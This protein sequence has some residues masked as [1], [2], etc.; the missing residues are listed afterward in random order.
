MR[1][2]IRDISIADARALMSAL[3]STRP[4][5]RQ[6]IGRDGR[7]GPSALVALEAFAGDRPVNHRD[8]NI[9]MSATE[10]NTRWQE[11]L[12]N[13][14][15]R[16]LFDELQI[17]IPGTPPTAGTA[18]APPPSSG[19]APDADAAA[20]EAARDLRRRLNLPEGNEMPSAVEVNLAMGIFPATDR[21]MPEA[22][23]ISAH[24][25][26]TRR[27]LGMPDGDTMPT[28]AD[29]VRLLN[30]NVSGEPTNQKIAEGLRQL[31]NHL[32]KEVNTL[33][34]LT[35]RRYGAGISALTSLQGIFSSIE[36]GASPSGL[37]A[38]SGLGGNDDP[39]TPGPFE[40]IQRFTSTRP[41]APPAPSPSPPL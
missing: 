12:K 25:A 40:R 32:N 16:G 33:N 24:I 2:Y 1:E 20:R 39:D 26:D 36:A 30:L 8:F 35:D 17:P 37:L 15:V 23:D 18:E 13:P 21:R 34:P 11:L 5:D 28:N 14:R 22:E 6:W 9:S 29:I 3:H 4:Q 10:L 41:T 31:Y 7:I 38:R 27:R 19:A